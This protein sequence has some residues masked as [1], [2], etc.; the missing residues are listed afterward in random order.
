MDKINGV[1]PLVTMAPTVGHHRDDRQTQHTSQVLIIKTHQT[2]GIKGQWKMSRLTVQKTPLSLMELQPV[3]GYCSR[4]LAQGHPKTQW[5]EWLT[6]EGFNVV[7]MAEAFFGDEEIAPKTKQ[8]IEAKQFWPF[9]SSSITFER[10]CM[11]HGGL[12]SI[13]RCREGLK[14]CPKFIF[15]H[16]KLE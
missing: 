2:E 11:G 1:K 15:C 4:S 14:I 7:F 10:V 6:S 3:N 12:H 13:N 16:I 8:P 5:R 9:F